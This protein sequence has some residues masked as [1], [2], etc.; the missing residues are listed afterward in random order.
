MENFTTYDSYGY[1]NAKLYE[2]APGSKI[3]SSN[4][5][6]LRI[7]S[8]ILIIMHHIAVHG[9]FTAEITAANLVWRNTIRVGGKVGVNLFIMISGYFLIDSKFKP[10]KLLKLI[11]QVIFYTIIIYFITIAINNESFNKANFIKEIMSFA[12]GYRYWFIPPYLIAYIL[13][14]YL[15]KLVQHCS[16]SEMLFLI[17]FLMFVQIILPELYGVEFMS[18]AVWFMTL[19]LIG[20]YIRVY[21]NHFFDDNVLMSCLFMVSL[22]IMVVFNVKL[23]IMQYDLKDVP[24][25]TATV[26]LFCWFKNLNI[27][28]SKTINL[29]AST[30]LGIY[31]LH[32]NGCI[33]PLFWGKIMHCPAHESLPFMQFFIY[34][35]VCIASVFIMGFILDIVR[36]LLFRY[37]EKL[38]EFIRKKTI[39]SKKKTAEA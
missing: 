6:L 33:R 32:D 39:H 22:T 34:T 14:P 11:L 28:N 27:K 31:L 17:V 16:Q 38:I 8:M 24:C 30:T 5:E 19:Y 37:S 35:T 20:S 25:F 23:K 36:Q 18:N 15:K 12:T 7:V 26:A 1:N 9:G 2:D 4:L 3:R 29:I 13:S 10:K 21:K